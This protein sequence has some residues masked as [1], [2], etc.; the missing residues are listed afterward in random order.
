MSIRQAVRLNPPAPPQ[1]GKIILVG[2]TGYAFRLLADGTAQLIELTVNGTF[3]LADI[4]AKDL[5]TFAYLLQNEIG[6]T[7]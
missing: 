6:G 7:R 5:E 3:T 1:S 4:Q 2:R